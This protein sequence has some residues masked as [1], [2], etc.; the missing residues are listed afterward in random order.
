MLINCGLYMYCIDVVI[1]DLV[2]NIMRQLISIANVT[3]Q[4]KDKTIIH[5]TNV[6]CVSHAAPIK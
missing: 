3:P 1:V 5:N 6:N 2:Y 4:M